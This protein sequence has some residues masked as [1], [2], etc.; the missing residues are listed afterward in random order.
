VPGCWRVGESDQR[1]QSGQGT[2]QFLDI[3]AVRTFG[4][5]K[6]EGLCERDSPGSNVQFRK[7]KSQRVGNDRTPWAGQR[8]QTKPGYRT[9][10]GK[11]KICIPRDFSPA[12]ECLCAGCCTGC[13]E[14]DRCEGNAECGRSVEIQIDGY[15]WKGRIARAKESRNHP[16][17]E[18]DKTGKQSVFLS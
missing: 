11:C 1:L 8:H 16:V 4:D 5:R 18:F 14:C 10:S 6:G 7:S 15:G 12:Q 17:Y 13:F 9:E 2:I 3:E